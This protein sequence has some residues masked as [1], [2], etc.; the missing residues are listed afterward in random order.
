MTHQA[1]DTASAALLRL[2]NEISGILGLMEKEMRDS[3]GNTNVN[4]LRLR[5]DEA[6]AVLASMPAPAAPPANMVNLLREIDR[7]V[8][9]V[10]VSGW[11]PPSSKGYVELLTRLRAALVA[12]AAPAAPEEEKRG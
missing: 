8:H 1:T 10:A 5:L 6:D 2:R 7:E 11:M 12:P 9:H 4:V 3:V